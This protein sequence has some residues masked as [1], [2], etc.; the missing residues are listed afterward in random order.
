MTR[1]PKDLT[2]EL[3]ARYLLWD[4]AVKQAGLN[5]ILTC[6]ARSEAEQHALYAQGLCSL[7]Q[8]NVLREGVGLPKITSKENHRVTWTMQSRHIV[9]SANTKSRAFDFA[10]LRPG[11][12]EVE[13]SLRVDTND[14][15]GPDYLEAG[16]LWEEVGGEWGGRWIH[17]DPPHCQ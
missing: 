3:Y 5:Y 15:G 16:Q 4:K 14:K 1:N 13:W 8:V 2:P 11:S 7:S 6:V 12:S 17:S 9:N 10:L